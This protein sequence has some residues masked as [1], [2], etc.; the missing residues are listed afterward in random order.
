M[1]ISFSVWGARI[2]PAKFEGVML[3]IM[4]NAVF[5]DVAECGSC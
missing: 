4:K 2:E 5:W 1:S 3:A